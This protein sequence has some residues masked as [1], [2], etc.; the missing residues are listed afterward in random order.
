MRGPPPLRR[1]RVFPALI[2][3]LAL[4]AHSRADGSPRGFNLGQALESCGVTW[5]HPGRNS[6]DSMPLGN[7]AIG[8]NVWTEPGG[9]LLFYIGA[10]DAWTEDPAGSW[11]LAKLGRI[12]VSLSP[13]ALGPGEPFVQELKLHDGEIIVKEGDAARAVVLRVWVDAN[14]PVIH[15]EATSERPAAV[16]VA[17]EDWRTA[18][19]GAT[20]PDIVFA[21]RKGRI[22]WCHHDGPGSDPHVL[23]LTFGAVISGRGFRSVDSHTLESS[24]ESGT[25]A[26]SISP[27]TLPDTVPA[28]WLAEAE[29]RAAIDGSVDLEAERREHRRYWD[30]FWHRSWIFLKGR[31]QAAETTQGY[32]LQRFVTAC[33]GRGRYPIKFN[34]SLFVVDQ[35]AERIGG[36]GRVYSPVSADYRM[37]GGSYWFQNTRAMYWPRLA[38][39]DFDE[40]QPFFRMYRDLLPANAALVRRYYGHGG[41]YCAETTPFWGGLKDLKGNGE[42]YYGDNYYTDLLELTQMGLDYWEYTGD[43]GFLGGTVLPVAGAIL[44]FFD[45]HFPRDA[46]GR[47][48]L[49]PDN[50]LETYWKVRNPA[51]DIAGL[52]AVLD[53]LLALPGGLVPAGDRVAWQR[54]R[55]ELPELPTGTVGGRKVLLPCEGPLS[56][57]VR[58]SENPELYAIHPFRLFGVGRPGLELARDTFAVRR[59]KR[60]GCWVQ[61]PIQAAMLGLPDLARDDVAFDLTRRDPGEKFPA[62]WERGNDY[63]PD[64]DNGGNGEN[65]LQQMLLQADGRRLFLLPAWPAGWDADFKLHAPLQTTVEGSVR[66]GRLTALVVTPSARRRDIELPPGQR[67]P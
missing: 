25:R 24:P 49:D 5:T 64:E 38:A 54:I 58:N 15:V 56:A 11:G 18:R 53:R 41:A 12:R 66:G 44:T 34:G 27:L 17:L 7:G 63:M 32:V 65:G 48:V 9:D 61:D 67:L 1:L 13:R 51:P 31:N 6:S 42:G 2:C 10:T 50:A 52:H 57:K 29:R 19:V 40:M 62:F 39:G 23:N 36:Q 4:A 21:G 22:A 20:S 46:S 14:H 35:A 37:W 55:S 30:A 43:R 16:R 8:L 33:A 3:L 45:G 28:V 60:S 26:I 59:V 47:L